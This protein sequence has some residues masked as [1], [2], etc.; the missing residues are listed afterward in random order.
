[1][2]RELTLRI[3]IESPPA[4]VDYALQKGSGS[5]YEP[6]QKQRST[7]KDLHF[8][9][10]PAIRDDVSDPMRALSGPYVQGPP[11]Q[12][13]GRY[14]YWRIR[15]PGNVSMEPPAEDS[16]PGSAAE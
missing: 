14:R 6:V 3:I 13:F 5:G 7:D 9:F 8:E 1:M 15:G 2:S 11:G 4:G 10:T 16:L 12:R